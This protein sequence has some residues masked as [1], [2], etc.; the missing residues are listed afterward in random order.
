MI[1]IVVGLLLTISI[2]VNY[3]LYRKYDKL[4]QISIENEQF[5]LAIRNRVL[6]QRSYLQQLDRRG[7]FESDDEVGVF[8]KELK[9]IINDIAV[10][11]D[12]DSEEDVNM[13]S[14]SVLA[15]LKNNDEWGRYGET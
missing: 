10:Y 7:S 8:F 15:S 9:K 5:I 2:F 11:L 1:L 3:N 13:R 12:M 14:P 4:E 6:S